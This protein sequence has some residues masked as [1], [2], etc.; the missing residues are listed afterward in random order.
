VFW[1]S[2]R[3]WQGIDFGKAMAG[4]AQNVANASTIG[5]ENRQTEVPKSE[6]ESTGLV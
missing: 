1:A 3:Q 5:R 2:V 4:H 6:R